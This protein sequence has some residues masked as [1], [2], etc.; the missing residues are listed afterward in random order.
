MDQGI[1]AEMAAQSVSN[2][3]EVTY[4][5]PTY[6]KELK[7]DCLKQDFMYA[8]FNCVL[9]TNTGIQLVT[10]HENSATKATMIQKA[11][12]ER[13]KD[14][15]DATIIAQELLT[16]ITSCDIS[17]WRGSTHDFDLNWEEQNRRYVAIVGTTQAIPS[18]TKDCL[19]K[20][21]VRS[22]PALKILR[23]LG[24]Y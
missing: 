14:S 16:Y 1:K 18:V 5:E 20:N 21:A 2:I 24:P 19:L 23:R 7:V 10:E 8:M 3:C 12:M 17:D 13:T 6:A 9:K 11:T 15:T 4:V 22:I